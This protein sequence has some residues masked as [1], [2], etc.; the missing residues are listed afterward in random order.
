MLLILAVFFV[1]NFMI[2]S[3][4]LPTSAATGTTVCKCTNTYQEGND[5]YTKD[6]DGS[7]VIL[8]GDDNGCFCGGTLGIVRTAMNIAMGGIA[9]LATIGIIWAGIM[10][11]TARE[12]AEQTA[13]AKKRMLQVVVGLAAFG[14]IDL[15]GNMLLPGGIASSAPTLVS[16]SSTRVAG[17]DLV[18]EAPASSTTSSV[19]TAPS[20]DDTTSSPSSNPSSSSSGSTDVTPLP[21]TKGSCPSGKSGT[22]YYKQYSYT[23][24]QWKAGNCNKR[25]CGCNYMVSCSGCPMIAALNAINKTL[26]CNYA[27][28]D[29]AAYMKRKTN[30]FQNRAG[31]FSTNGEWSN[32]GE[33]IIRYYVE[34][35]AGINMKKIKSSEV[36]G[37]VRRG[38]AVIGNGNRG[39]CSATVFSKGGHYVM[40]SGMSGSKIKVENPAQSS[41]GK[42]VTPSNAVCGGKN[43]WVVY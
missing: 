42:L 29:F 14:M 19:T 4:P 40:Y 23:S 20:I 12:N 41:N 5:T 39:S 26:N 22:K 2:I 28:T 35:V 1:A 15:V 31:L 11:L 32:L 24:L 37:Y 17:A 27:P 36:E 8:F 3:N 33:K 38:N 34:D 7:D 9:V 6:E 21:S 30:N 18:I 10:W 13:K 43:F 16:S 25:N